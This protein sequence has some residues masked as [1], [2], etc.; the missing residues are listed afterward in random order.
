[1]LNAIDGLVEEKLLNLHTAGLAT[2]VSISGNTADIQPLSLTKHIGGVP[3]KQA[4]LD[5][6]PILEHVIYVA[7]QVGQ[8]KLAVG[9]V[10]MFVCCDR[11]I[12]QSKKGK[13]N[14]PTSGHHELGN[15]IIIGR[16]L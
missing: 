9:Q 1:M 8:T 11:E 6:V 3:Q 10:V 13:L 16:L 7:N 4:V 15:A 5:N 14:L 2:I 12:S